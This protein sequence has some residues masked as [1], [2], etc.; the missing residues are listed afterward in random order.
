VRAVANRFTADWDGRE[1]ALL[2]RHAEVQQTVWQAERDDDPGLISLMA[3]TGV[4]A[5]TAI[6]PAATVVET[7][8]SE[9]AAVIG[10]LGTLVRR[11]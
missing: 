2:A 3:G 9:A 8:V 7:L 1:E 11:D 5:I 4:A 6:T 10:A